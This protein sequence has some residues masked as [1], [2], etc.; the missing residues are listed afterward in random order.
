MGFVQAA[1]D[2]NWI[3]PLGPQVDAFEQEF[4]QVVGVPY[5]AAVSS[6]T[7]A[8]HLALL[9]AGV[10][11]DDSVLCSTL[12]FVASANAIAYTGA[13]PVF[14]DSDRE[15][16]TMDPDLLGDDLEQRAS[17]GELPKA[18]VVVDLY[19]QAAD[20]DR[21]LQV[22]EQHEV[23]VIQDAAEAL[24]AEYRGQPVGGSGMC[25]IFS[26]NG[27]KIITTSGGGMLVSH[28]RE[29]IDRARFL[30]TQARDPG[31]HHEHSVVGY[32]Y[33]LSN[34]LAGVGRGQ[35]RHLNE[36]VEARRRN[37]DT[38]VELLGALPGVE[39]MPEADYGRSN[40]WLSCLTIDPAAFGSDRE[41]VRVALEAK[42]IEARPLWMPMHM[43]PVFRGRPVVGGDVA[44]DLFDRGLCL[45]SGSALT[46]PQLERIASIV[47]SCHRP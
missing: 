29:L 20:Y 42:N 19:G 44:E 13:T 6:G 22:C 40:R 25:A 17:R 46:R 35:L 41:Q 23:V 31:P 27:N 36:R 8:L 32:N 3:A 15:T 45:P 16:W 26:F 30:S 34:I 43:Q 28:N 39:F 9:E 21:I 38:Y 24:G 2:S 1:F 4:A 14:V 11:P 33:R 47:A 5:A 7:A 37:F 10:G 18:V 12:T